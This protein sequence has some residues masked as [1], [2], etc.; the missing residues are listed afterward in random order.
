[1]PHVLLRFMATQE[2]NKLTLSRRIATVW[3]IIS[4]TVAIFIGVVGLAISETGKIAN[5]KGS[6]SETIIVKIADLL[7]SHGIA[8]SVIAGVILAGILAATMST[9]DSQLLAAASSISQNFLSDFLHIK[10]SAKASVA[11]ARITVIAISAVSVVIAWDPA[12]SVFQIVSFAWAGFGATFGPVMLLALFWK[13]SNKTGAL[14]GMIAGGV[15]VFAWKYLVRPMGGA[16]DIY[17]LL[18]AFLAALAVNVI[19]SLV[20]KAPDEAIVRE[21]EEVK[22]GK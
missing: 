18:P 16:L 9:S 13:R 20:T 6:D 11:A 17:E 15:F 8:A 12:S 21:F 1:M 2:E 14:C 7:S 3:V 22:A 10:M 4:M 5:L 19:V